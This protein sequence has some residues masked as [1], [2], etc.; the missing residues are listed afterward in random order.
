MEASDQRAVHAELL[1]AYQDYRAAMNTWRAAAK[2]GSAA[3]TEVA[4]ERLLRA[5]VAL[6]RVLVATGWGA[7]PAVA[8]QLDRDVALVEAPDD[9]EALLAV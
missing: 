8:A 3:T 6:Y 4:A 1:D 7:P 9:F 2:A 5:R